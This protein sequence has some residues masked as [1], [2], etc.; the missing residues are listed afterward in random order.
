MFDVVYLVP[1]NLLFL[2]LLL[3]TFKI[4]GFESNFRLI[5]PTSTNGGDIS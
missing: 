5:Q 2:Y 1:S 4:V 3:F